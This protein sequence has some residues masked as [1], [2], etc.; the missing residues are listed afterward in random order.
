MKIIVKVRTK[1]NSCQQRKCKFWDGKA[2]TDEIKYIN[3]TDGEACCR[4]HPD[5]IL[6][7][8]E[9]GEDVK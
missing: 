5:A 8:R 9:G 4:Y 3:S 6:K 7:E 2:C 1:M